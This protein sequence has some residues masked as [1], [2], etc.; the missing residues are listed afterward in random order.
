[1]NQ[2]G[3]YDAREKCRKIKN[4][5]GN[6]FIRDFANVNPISQTNGTLSASSSSEGFETF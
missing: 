1:M 2:N 4:K 3:T 6:L 5:G